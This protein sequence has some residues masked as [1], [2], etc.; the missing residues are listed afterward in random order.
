MSQADGTVFFE[1]EM[2][3]K[4]FEQNIKEVQNSMQN[5]GQSMQRAGGRMTKWVTGPIALAGTALLGL[6]G[7]VA[8]YADA[9]LDLSDQTGMSTERIQEWQAVADQAGVSQDA[10]T[11]GAKQLTRQMHSIEEGTGKQAE[12]IEALGL[13]YEE[14][15]NA[16]PDERMDML[17]DALRGVE[18]EGERARLGTDLLRGSYDELAP[19]LG[20][21]SDEIENVTDKAHDSGRIMSEDALEDANEYRKAMEELKQEFMG[22][23][24]EVVTDLM[25]VI[26]DQ[27]IPFIREEAV[28]MMRNLGETIGELITWFT[29]LSPEVQRY[30]GIAVGLAAALG[31]VLM[32]FGSMINLIG[33]M[34]PLVL[35]LTKFVIA[36]TNPWVWVGAVI[37][38]LVALMIKNWDKIWETTTEVFTNIKEAVT[39][40]IESARDSIANGIQRARDLASNAAQ[41]LRDRV[42]SGI[43][44][45]R[46]GVQSM[47]SS[48]ANFFSNTWNAIAGRARSFVNTFISIF[49]GIKSGIQ[50]ALSPVMNI[51]NRIIS[52]VESMIN[53][54]GSAINSLPSFNI[55]SWV[56]GVGGGS[57]G[58]PNI[59]NISLPSI[60]HL[61]DGVSYALEYFPEGEVVEPVGF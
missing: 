20:M 6:T 44:S 31:P 57:F 55:P 13:E 50:S 61:D 48:V 2:D 59:P 47:V 21:T 32:G 26:K 9:V 38:A 54:V 34:L 14:L 11:N 12:A 52:A 22:V 51:F 46:D 28:P 15:D 23:V 18:D 56:P 39:D 27:L 40:R 4:K 10:V 1:A 17:M 60:P 45:M 29:N 5:M 35:K 41:S 25:P 58:L 16:S 8:N 33:T 42:V 30:M 49:Q 43:T 24:R 53:G 7:K 36:F 3:K 19:I 37:V